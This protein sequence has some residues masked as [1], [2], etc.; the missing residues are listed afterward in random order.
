MVTAPAD[1]SANE[2]L[3]VDGIGKSFRDRVV[4]NHVSLRLR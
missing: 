4:V 1:T 2:G 3:I